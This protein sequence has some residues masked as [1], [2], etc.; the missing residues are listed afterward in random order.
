MN[1]SVETIQPEGP[2]NLA[3]AATAVIQ[4]RSHA[5]R[6]RDELAIAADILAELPEE[7]L[8]RAVASGQ[9]RETL[10]ARYRTAIVLLDDVE[11]N[12]TV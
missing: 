7:E 3:R 12:L 9:D 10:V 8:R 5:R 1:G 2:R 11:Q 6:L 4:A